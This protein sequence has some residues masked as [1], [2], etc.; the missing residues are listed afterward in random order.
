MHLL[1]TPLIYRLLAFQASPRYTKLLGVVLCVL[2][3]TVIITHMVLDEFLLH[4]S[5]F[6]LGVFLI[7]TRTLKIVGQISSPAVSRVL[8]NVAILGVCKF[9]GSESQA[10]LTSQSA[11][12]LDIASGSST[13]TCATP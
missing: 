3:T 9:S 1:I 8:R 6:G 12:C 4:A 13:V 2:F 10:L 11:S 7:Q 5:T